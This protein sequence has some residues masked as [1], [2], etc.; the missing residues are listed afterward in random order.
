MHQ[1]HV[2]V[3][4]NDYLPG[5]SFSFDGDG[6]TYYSTVSVKYFDI[7][8]DNRLIRFTAPED[9][10]M[11]VSTYNIIDDQVITFQIFPT[12]SKNGIDTEIEELI[13][14]KDSLVKTFNNKYSRFIQEGT[15]TSTDYIDAELYYLD[16]VQVGNTSSQPKVSY[17]INVVEVSEL[18]GYEWYLFD[19]GE[20]TYIEDTEFFGWNRKNIG[21]TEE[22][23]YILQPAREEVII[24]EVEWHLEDPSSNTIT[25]QNYKTQFEDF[26]QRV[27]ATVQK[28]EYN[29][30]TYAK[31]SSILD[32]NGTINQN[33]LANSLTNL[34]G[35]EYS[36]T[37]DGSV[38]VKGDVIL[39]QNLLNQANRVVIT[40]EGIR[41][42]SNGGE[43]YSTVIDGQGIN[44]SM[45]YTGTLNT[46]EVIIG[47]QENPSF[48]W[49][50][51]GIS[52]FKL[53]ENDTSAPYDLQTFVR[54][55]QYGLYGIKNNSAFKA[56]SLSDILNKAH[57]AV[58]W[59][60]F[61]IKNSYPGGGRV[62]ITSDNDFRVMNIPIGHVNEQEKIK[63]GALEWGKDGN[64][65]ITSPDAEG[66]TE[67]PTLYGI[68]IRNNVGATV[69]KTGDDGNLEITGTIYANAGQIGGMEVDDDKLSMDTI[70]L[71]P[72]VGIYTTVE[73]SNNNPLFSISDVDGSATFRYIEALGGLLGNLTV[74]DVITVGALGAIESAN[75][76]ALD[77]WHIDNYSA[78]FNNAN[79]RGAI[80]AL[81][82]NFLGIVNVGPTTNNQEHI[83]IDGTHALIR[84]SGYQD[85]AGAG[86][87]INKKG[88]AYFNNI[89]ARGAIKTAV[90]EYSEVQS[91][92]GVFLFRPSSTIR[93]ATENGNDLVLTVE[94][95]LL[96]S[97]GHWCKVSNYI[98]DGE[99]TDPEITNIMEAN[100]LTH[101]Y[102][103]SNITTTNGTTYITLDG[104]KALLT[105]I[106]QNAEALDAGVLVGGALINMGYKE[107]T[108]TQFVPSEGSN[109]S[110]LGIYEYV[111]ATQEYVLTEDT[112][113]VD[114]K[115]YYK[116]R[117]EGGVH[118]YGI[119]INSSDN[120]VN[121]PARAIS[122]FET[123]INEQSEPKVTYKYKAILGTLPTLSV[124]DVDRSIYTQ[125]ME[126][127][128]GV[129]TNNLYIGDADQ[130]IAF[131]EDSSSNKH[132]KIKAQDIVYEVSGGREVTYA[133]KIADIENS[134]PAAYFWWDSA[135][136]HVASGDS[137]VELDR[138]DPSTY[139]F[140]ALLTPNLLALRQKG[141]NLAGLTT[142][143][144]TFYI[145][146][147]GT[148]TQGPKALE[149]GTSGL[150]MYNP[151]AGN[152]NVELMTLLPGSI[153]FK[154]TNGDVQ[155]TF[156]A[157]G[158]IQSGNYARGT[159]TRFANSGMKIDLIYGEILTPNFRLSQ[160]ADSNVPAGAYIQGTI[161][162]LDGKIGG[163]S[164]N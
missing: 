131:Y 94:K 89:T 141:I 15:W 16:A 120:T 22:P 64:I 103:V 63:I 133:D 121:L 139:G 43:S 3:S 29:E 92:S 42:S 70:V 72:G 10:V 87:L 31:T 8:T 124:Y 1:R 105:A 130:Y 96:F 109:P 112:E 48:R 30:A 114:G 82:G 88:D 91:V 18:E 11:E 106:G 148:T 9:Y 69:L 12:G 74:T 126:G 117:Y 150:T 80:T 39:I 119:G 135:G 99:V 46:N 56:Q 160:G 155:A 20:K 158:A 52:A 100:G 136:S 129:Y 101:V 163:D 71:E 51:A 57:F 76:S 111:A 37:S 33:V 34:G 38:I 60:G 142:N 98:A 5:F 67:A 79:V 161:E 146:P 162:A 151:V 50:K 41:V 152:S 159:D 113:I 6:S 47:N 25:V 7:T 28:V 83:I 157:N 140:N 134:T 62:E 26:F 45:V 145:P 13:E 132:L 128:Q 144:L 84:S 58:T 102:R 65:P 164:T 75:Y 143:A 73:D 36:L 93:S 97:V 14:E 110:E 108:Y 27:G 154:N 19:A 104:A 138:S 21:T 125:Y 24:S 123:A 66:A 85:G 118:N 53:D 86:W 32:A 59:D 54:F 55:D 153:T 116:E 23:E 107:G 78:T 2:F 61:F 49:D 90:F 137:L 4:L 95:P 149:I 147:N 17:T 68:R 77:G 156:G 40:S 127:S 115:T 122:L 81:E 44:I 35:K